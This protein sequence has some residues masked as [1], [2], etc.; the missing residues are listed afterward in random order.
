MGMTTDSG[1]GVVAALDF[2]RVQVNPDLI[3]RLQRYRHLER[4]PP[5]VRDASRQMA[6]LAETLAV[7]QGWTW[8][9]PVVRADPDGTVLI[10]SGLA[11]QSHTLERLLRGAVEAVIV[12]V[13]I[14]PDL[15]RR[16]HELV[17]LEQYV[18]G[19]LLDTAGWVAI[20]ALFKSLRRHL[21]TEA[22]ARGLR[23]TGR[24]APGFADW[25]L[26][27]Q[28]IL[29]SAFGEVPVAVR[30]TEACVMLPRKSAS[31]LYG[32]VPAGLVPGGLVHEDLMPQD[33]VPESSR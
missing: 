12:L 8:C 21:A 11:F 5:F 28:Q 16:A 15:E 4:V 23:L 19:L 10:G 6:E 27:Q 20:D 26:E 25:G 14:G 30:L 9:G 24:L 7:P 3:L 32:L 18:E 29:F 31:G 22:R 1:G 13:T 17:G 33:L 2:G